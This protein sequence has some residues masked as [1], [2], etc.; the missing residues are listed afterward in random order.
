[1]RR[2]LAWTAGIVACAVIGVAGWIYGASEWRLR[3]QW[4]VPATPLKVAIDSVSVA[5]GELV[6]RTRGCTGCHGANLG[7]QVFFDEP[8]LARLVPSNLTKVAAAVSDADLA[9]MIRDGVRPDGRALVAMPSEMFY[10]LSDQDVA[11]LI[12]YIRTRPVVDDTLP[13]RDVRIL[14][15]LG[16][17]LGEFQTAP[18]LIDRTNPRLGNLPAARG[19]RRGEYLVRTTCPECHG[20]ELE[21]SPDPVQPIPTLQLAVGYSEQEFLDL[22]RHGRVKSGRTLDLM[23]KVLEGRLRH[24]SD[25]DLRAIHSFLVTYRIPEDMVP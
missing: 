11:D 8:R 16:L 4:P 10:H 2:I 19:E 21:G 25:D 6:A 13:G 17:V 1:M 9:R 7:G 18:E 23:G 15:R 22:V 5:R 24:F 12:A 3:K 20:L 14:G